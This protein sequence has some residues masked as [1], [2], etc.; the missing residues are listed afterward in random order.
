MSPWSSRRDDVK[1]TTAMRRPPSG[2]RSWSLVSQV[3]SGSSRCEPTTTGWGSPSPTEDDARAWKQ[4]AEHRLA[5]Q[6][7]R[8]RWYESY[9]V[10]IATVTRS[11]AFDC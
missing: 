8:D 6:E 3:I 4:V 9:A 11:Y 5:R 10:R 2:W 1:E 7:G